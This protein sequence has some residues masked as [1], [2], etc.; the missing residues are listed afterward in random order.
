MVWQV[1]ELRTYVGRGG[2]IISAGRNT[3]AGSICAR[4]NFAKRLNAGLGRQRLEERVYAG[5]SSPPCVQM[6]ASPGKQPLLIQAAVK[7]VHHHV[8]SQEC[9]LV[10]VSV[11]NPD[12]SPPKQ[13]IKLSWPFPNI[14][15]MICNLRVRVS[16][17]FHMESV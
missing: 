8:C 6:A 2:F 10:W 12:S 3:S 17:V 5:V 15:K 16:V 4:C 9:A 11:D 7:L 13:L 14:L 1:N